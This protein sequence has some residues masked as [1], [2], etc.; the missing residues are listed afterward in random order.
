MELTA[1][2]GLELGTGIGFIARGCKTIKRIVLQVT[3]P[4]P[5]PGEAPPV[6]EPD[7]K[8]DAIDREDFV[9]SAREYMLSKHM[10][11]GKNFAMTFFKHMV[12]QRLRAN[13]QKYVWMHNGGP[14]ELKTSWSKISAVKAEGIYSEIMLGYEE[15]VTALERNK[16]PDSVRSSKWARKDMVLNSRMPDT[17]FER[18]GFKS[19]LVA[20]HDDLTTLK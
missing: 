15:I 3:Q 5:E 13:Q 19:I 1:E 18:L 2:Q 11:W 8:W 16:K 20:V 9:E 4:P 12:K 7:E 17:L 10:L 6:E 14:R